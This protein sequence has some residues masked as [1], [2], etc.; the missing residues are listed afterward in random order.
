MVRGLRSAGGVLFVKVQKSKQALAFWPCRM[1][2]LRGVSVFFLIF[3]G[4]RFFFAPLA[5]AKYKRLLTIT[6][7]VLLGAWAPG[8]LCSW[9][10]GRLGSWAPRLLAGWAGLAGL[11]G[12]HCDIHIHSHLA[13]I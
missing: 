6:A 3:G 12:C 1:R 8:R 13:C 2:F 7:P 11:A 10:P 5:H 4:F 9:A